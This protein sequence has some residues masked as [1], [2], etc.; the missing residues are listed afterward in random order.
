MRHYSCALLL[1]TTCPTAIAV[2]GVPFSQQLIG[3]GGFVRCYTWSLAGGSLAPLTLEQRWTSF[4]NP[5][6]SGYVELY[7]RLADTTAGCGGTAQQACTITVAAITFT[8]NNSTTGT[9]QTTLSVALPQ[10]AASTFT[11]TLTLTFTPDPG[12]TSLPAGYVDPA[13]G[14]P[15]GS[16][17]PTSFTFNFTIP[18]GATQPP[19]PPA[20][21]RGTV[22]GTWTATLTALSTGGTSALVGSPP[23]QTVVIP[24]AAPVINANTVKIINVTSTGFA[25]ELS[26]SVTS[27]AVS[28]ASFMFTPAAGGQLSGSSV[29]LPF[30]GQDQTQWF[31]TS[32]GQAAGGTFSLLVPFG[33]TGDPAA[34]GTVTVTLTGPQ[35]TSVAVT[36][37]E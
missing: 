9:N 16:Q 25:V 10:A 3:T 29:T 35:G 12:L 24:L 19:T 7:R 2:V 18:Q 37:G 22:A 11:G 33:Y 26:G 1:G 5:N 23:A 4:R 6:G 32:A 15:I 36:G 8:Q 21:G 27:R 30:N 28:S 20:F 34:I 31:N 13:G 14:F 17:S